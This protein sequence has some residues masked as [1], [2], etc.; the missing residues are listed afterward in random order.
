M[1]ARIHRVAS[2]DRNIG[3]LNRMT[4]SMT[5][6]ILSKLVKQYA[7]SN[8]FAKGTNGLIVQN[9]GGPISVQELYH[10]DTIDDDM[11]MDEKEMIVDEDAYD[12]GDDE[13]DLEDEEG[14]LYLT[15]TVV[16]CAYLFMSFFVVV[17]QIM[18]TMIFH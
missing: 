13:Q 4:D 12:D 6:P 11:D 18:Q 1:Q 3:R 5:N 16:H 9:G 7:H 17:V 8:V 14:W 10:H 15:R 2:Q